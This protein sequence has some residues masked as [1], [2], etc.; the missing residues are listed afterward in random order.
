MGKLTRGVKPTLHDQS[1]TLPHLE[2]GQIQKGCLDPPPSLTLKVTLTLEAHAE[3]R[4]VYVKANNFCSYHISAIADMGAQTR[5]FDPE[6]QK[7]LRYADKYLVPTTASD[8][9]QWRPG[10]IRVGKYIWVLLV[11]I[12]FEELRPPVSRF[13]DLDFTAKCGPQ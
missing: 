2:W 8:L 11:R 7:T 3:L 12:S 4:Y 10:H 5:S 6:I 9:D 1:H 13:T